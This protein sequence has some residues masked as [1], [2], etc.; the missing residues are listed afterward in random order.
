MP[1]VKPR[2]VLNKSVRHRELTQIELLSVL[3][4]AEAAELRGVNPDTLRRNEPE[5]ILNISPGRY[6]MRLKDALM[7]R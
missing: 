3:S 1:R 4:L 7:L 2:A 5:K 6:G